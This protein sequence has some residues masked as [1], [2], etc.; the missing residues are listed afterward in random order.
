MAQAS[1]DLLD[2]PRIVGARGV[3][4]E[5]RR[6]TRGARARDG[7]LYPV[8]NGVVPDLARAPDVSLLDR[9]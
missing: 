3:E 7:Q 1:L 6:R 2:E 8:S 5:D 9:V 4:P